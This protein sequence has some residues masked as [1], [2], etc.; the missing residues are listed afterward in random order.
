MYLVM[1]HLWNSRCKVRRPGMTCARV[2][3]GGLTFLSVVIAWVL[4]RA[5]NVAAAKAMLDGMIG[6]NGIDIP[7]SQFASISAVLASL[8]YAPKSLQE[9]EQG[10]FLGG[11]VLG[12][13]AVWLFPNTSQIFRKF[14][15]GVD[16]RNHCTHTVIN[17]RPSLI[18]SAVLTLIFFASL[19]KQFGAKIPSPFLYFQF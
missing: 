8:A 19:A 5:D 15:P 12:A 11:A 3:G 2:V 18:W 10:A 4:F 14:S 7:T 16:S 17:W 13:V 9:I 1:Y 6:A